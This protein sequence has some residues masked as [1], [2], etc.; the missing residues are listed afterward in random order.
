MPVNKF[1]N[2]GENAEA[3]TTFVKPSSGV[4]VAE[5]NNLFLRR[6]GANSALGNLD[7][8]NHRVVNIPDPTY[9]QDIVNRRCVDRTKVDKAGDT[10]NG[11]LILKIKNNPT[12]SIG[13]NDLRDTK[14]FYVLLGND[15]NMIQA[16][17]GLPIA[18]QTT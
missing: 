7:M 4:N 12:I 6:D 18:I 2:S 1:G 11:N 5:I 8:N 16:Q 15:L 9:Q 14:K 3:S 13:C 10:M 17:V